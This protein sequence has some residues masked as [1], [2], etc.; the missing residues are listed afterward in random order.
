VLIA[1]VLLFFFASLLGGIAQAEWQLLAAR[2]LL[3]V[4]IGLLIAFGAVRVLSESPRQHGRFDLAGAFTATIGLVSL[5]YGLTQKGQP[6][7]T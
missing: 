4:P 6:D 7:S 2:A 5:V 3:N 1:G